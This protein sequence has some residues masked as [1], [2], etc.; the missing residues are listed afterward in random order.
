MDLQAHRRRQKPQYVDL[1]SALSVRVLPRLADRRGVGHLEETLP[2][3]ADGPHAIEWIVEISRPAG[4][5]FEYG[6]PLG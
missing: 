5:R 4:G 2:A 1:A 3:V 6:G